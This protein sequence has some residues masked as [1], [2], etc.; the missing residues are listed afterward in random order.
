MTGWLLWLALGQAQAAVEV[1][2]VEVAVVDPHLHTLEH[3]GD[4]NVEGKAFI[5]RQLPGFVA[6]YYPALVGKISDPYEPHIG[7]AAQLD[8]AGVDQG[9]LLAAYTHHTVGFMTNTALADLLQDP[10][11]QQ[12]D[13]VRFYGLASILLDGT[14]ETDVM[15]DRLEAL[16]SFL[17][18]PGRHFIGIKLAH[19]HQA[20]AMDDP[21]VDQVYAVA[22]EVGVPVLLHTGVS[23][24]PGTRQEP[25]YT[26]PADLEVAIVRHDGS[27]SEGRVEFVLSHV[28]TGDARA[29][30]ASLDLAERYD[31]VWL[32][33]SALK[34]ALTIDS[35]GLPVESTT[36]QYEWVLEAILSRGLVDRAIFAT[37]GPQ[38]SGKVREYLQEIISVMQE[39]EYTT[40]QIEAV[41]SGNF[42]RCFSR[43]R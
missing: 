29:T 5:L 24:F 25:E 31:N 17:V 22:G 39:L 21:W 14:P 6:P 28:G 38:S 27:G 42:Y 41:L 8:W 40:E 32:E 1:N 16:E 34:S 2:G 43:A 4:L 10:R 18:D 36:P 15:L 13:S 11:N 30:E 19:A 7:I 26:S 20:V 9:V 23:P 35:D 37:D 12:G 33:L 3:V